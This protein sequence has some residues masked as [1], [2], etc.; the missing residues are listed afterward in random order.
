MKKLIASSVILYLF[1]S[2]AI[3]FGQVTPLPKT[4]NVTVK[5]RIDAQGTVD[6]RIITGQNTI[7][8]ATNKVANITAYSAV[9]SYSVTSEGQ[10]M[11]H[12]VCV[13]KAPAPTIDNPKYFS[14]GVTGPSFSAEMNGL[15]PNMKYYVRAFAKNSNGTVFYGNELS[16]TTLPPK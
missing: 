9:C 5:N 11:Q 1:F 12:G 13:N 15:S 10:I 8:V 3:L 4:D 7:H 2:M 16:F 14:K 6:K